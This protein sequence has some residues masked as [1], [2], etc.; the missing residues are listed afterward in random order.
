MPIGDDAGGDAGT[1]GVGAC[2][3]EVA[4]VLEVDLVDGGLADL[5]GEAGDQEALVVAGGAV[6]GG[7]AVG[8][9][10]RAAVAVGAVEV[11]EVVVDEG[12]VAAVDVEV[13]AGEEEVLLGEARGRCCPGAMLA[14]S[15]RKVMPLAHWRGR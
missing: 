8:E 15:W 12:V 3:F 11:D 13:E 4:T 6:G 10:G 14:T 7:R 2:G 5:G 1:G 9:G